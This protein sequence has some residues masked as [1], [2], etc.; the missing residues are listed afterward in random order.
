M[1][2][3]RRKSGFVPFKKEVDDESRFCF[4]PFKKGRREEEEFSF[5]RDVTIT[6]KGILIF[7]F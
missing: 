5:E 4:V 2:F 7:L 3:E 6:Q 1:L